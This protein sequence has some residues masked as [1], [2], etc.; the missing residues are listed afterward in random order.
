LQDKFFEKNEQAGLS[1]VRLALQRKLIFLTDGVFLPML[2][3]LCF[4]SAQIPLVPD[5]L[6]ARVVKSS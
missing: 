4:F 2:K 3:L 1:K 6:P 5:R